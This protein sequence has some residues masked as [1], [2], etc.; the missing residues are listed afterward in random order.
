[1]VKTVV[2]VEKSPASVMEPLQNEASIGKGPL[3]DTASGG[4][5]GKHLSG[6]KSCA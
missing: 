4:S 2:R 3:S 5:P 1:M 6:K